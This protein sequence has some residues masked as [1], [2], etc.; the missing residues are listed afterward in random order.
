[1]DI[2]AGNH[3]MEGKITRDRHDT[4]VFFLDCS[5]DGEYD[6]QQ[7]LG[8]A[9]KKNECS[10]SVKTVKD[11]KSEAENCKQLTIENDQGSVIF[12]EKTVPAEG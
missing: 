9:D 1:M 11:T 4:S 5:A 7:F 2:G 3:V 6:G 12:E 10:I 8:M